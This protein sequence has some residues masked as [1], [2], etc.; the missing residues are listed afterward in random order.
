[1]LRIIVD[2]DIL[3][4]LAKS[5][6]SNHQRALALMRQWVGKVRIC[7]SPF[8]IPEA[9]TVLSYRVSQLAAKKF[10]ETARGKHIEELTVTDEITAL[11]DS[12]FLSQSSNG[13]SWPDC[14]NVAMYKYYKLDAISA[15]DKFYKK[16]KLKVLA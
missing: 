12:V 2:A 11:T 15:F 16:L 14:L 5:D 1:M 13:I 10:L 7:V 6:D 4:A 3:V 9:A 8:S